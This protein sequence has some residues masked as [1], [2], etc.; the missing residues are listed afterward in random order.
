[1]SDA[2]PPFLPGFSHEGSSPKAPAL[3]ARGQKFYDA[4]MASPVWAAKKVPV[5]SRAGGHCE[6]C[7]CTGR[8][9]EVHHRTYERFGGGELLTDLEAL[10]ADP[11]HLKADRERRSEVVAAIER[12]RREAEDAL[13]DGLF[14]TWARRKYGAEFFD[15]ADP[16]EIRD[17]REEYDESWNDRDG[18]DCD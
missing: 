16:D 8:V 5:L 15:G 17:A 1:M 11:C 14:R 13:D 2:P 12:R 7:G 6:R 10:C 4:Y 9:L 18:R 3:T